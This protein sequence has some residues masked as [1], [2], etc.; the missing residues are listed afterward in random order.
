MVLSMGPMTEGWNT[1]MTSTTAADTTSCAPETTVGRGS[2]WTAS[3]LITS[4]D[5]EH[6]L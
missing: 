6:A 5:D 3:L 2:S 4:M 1:R